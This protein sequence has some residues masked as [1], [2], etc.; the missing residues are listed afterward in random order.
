MPWKEMNAMEQKILFI[1]T[2]LSKLGQI[3]FPISL[4]AVCYKANLIAN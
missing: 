3:N 2:C 1:N 4:C